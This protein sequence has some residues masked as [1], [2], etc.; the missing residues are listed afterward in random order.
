[1]FVV[2]SMSELSASAGVLSGPVAFSFLIYL[3]DMLI[4]SIIGG[5]ASPVSSM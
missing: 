4:S 3:M 2:I 1:M 5:I